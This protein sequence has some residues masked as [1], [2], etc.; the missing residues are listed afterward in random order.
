MSNFLFRVLIRLDFLLVSGVLLF[1]FPL[2][3][4]VVVVVA[5][6]KEITSP[7]R[8]VNLLPFVS[9]DGVRDNRQVYSSPRCVG[10]WNNK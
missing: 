3:I 4:V 1:L 5:V 7:T 2:A 10:T 6:V 8:L 9:G